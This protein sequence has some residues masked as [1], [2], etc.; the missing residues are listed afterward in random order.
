[1]QRTGCRLREFVQQVFV[2]AVA[3]AKARE[4]F[5]VERKARTEAEA[6][7]AAERQSRDEVVGSAREEAEN[8]ARA[9]VETRIAAERKT[10]E[11]ADAKVAAAREEA[12]RKAQIEVEA[13]IDAE[14]KAREE[15]ERKR[16]Q[17]ETQAKQAMQ[18]SATA[19]KL[20]RE[21]ASKETS[22]AEKSRDE[23]HKMRDE[24][25]R[26]LDSARLQHE[27]AV[28]KAQAEMMARVHAEQK[29]IAEK[30]ARAAA[31]DRAKQEAVA[32][33]MQE[34]QMRQ[35]AEKD[36]H[37]KV[38]AEIKARAQA[39]FDADVKART[40]AQLR[41][42]TVAMQK[43]MEQEHAA[44]KGMTVSA[45]R[46]A[47]VKWGQFIIFGLILLV[48]AG[49]GILQ[50]APLNGYVPGAEKILSERL[51]EPVNISGLRLNL[52]PTPQLKIERI[53]IGKGQDVRIESATMAVSSL[54][55]LDERKEIDEIELS[56]VVIDQDALP[57]LAAWAQA[58]NA[59]P[60]LQVKRIKISAIKLA[61]RGVEMPSL[62]AVVTLGKDGAWQKFNVRDSKA[63]LELVPLKEPGQLRANFSAR[64]WTPP[65]G[66][67]V[68]F[69]D[70]SATA[71][72]TRDQAN[73]SNIDGR[74]FSGALKGSLVLKWGS[75]LLAEGELNLKG[76]DV[77]QV[78]AGFTR[79]FIASG[80][81]ETAMKFTTQG[82]TPD[83][84]FAA[85]RVTANFALQKGT[86][87]NLDLVRAIQ[88][89]SRTGLRGGKTPYTEITGEAQAAGNRISYRNLKL[90]AG[91]LNAT[92]AVDVSPAAELAGR[93]NVQLGTQSVSIARGVLNV[94]GGMKDPLLG[95]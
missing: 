91:P 14:R 15:A 84:L 6:E 69:S 71:T 46:K 9:E 92:G 73:I 53:A 62:D 95:Q 89:T 42:D 58:P 61:L 30:R 59:E 3:E 38:E 55:I 90:A 16:E 66:P 13:R 77:G 27:Q 54:A 81:L 1:M 44:A 83:E 10:R 19:E 21:A 20:I 86:L 78:L 88:S 43:A 47:P 17:A 28:A 49:V 7:V 34:H 72:L 87:S 22:V 57:R 4:E 36:I 26:M 37:A 94:S 39:E 52:F 25:Q 70:L 11:E 41:A 32:R 24:A 40:E 12:E 64:A 23:A 45:T 79:D 50:V 5:A 68:E 74:V 75:A 67:R 80:T 56:G 8:R 48:A 2:V 35:N 85:P 31:E 65:V 76:A 60:R 18:I 93:L 29:A 51:Q 33:V 63:N 82:Q